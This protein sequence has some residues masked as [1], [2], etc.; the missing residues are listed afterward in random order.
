MKKFATLLAVVACATMAL[1]TTTFHSATSGTGSISG[2]ITDSATGYPIADAKV[3]VNCHTYA[4][5]GNDGRYT[6]T[7]LAAGDY[8]VTAMKSG[9]AMKAYPTTV[10]VDD[11]QAVT[12]IDIALAASGGGG[13]NGSISGTVYDQ[14]TNQPI[15]GAK[16]TAG[17]CRRKATTASDGTYTITGLSD[18]FYTVRAMKSGYN[19]AT[20]PNQ[21]EI[22]NGGAVTGIDFYLAQR[23]DYTAD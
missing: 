15:S 20:Y 17:G 22:V 23:G 1:A 5:S 3:M 19:C 10:H 13:G 12:G 7:G 8:R 16:V 9:Y 21:V 11:G 4:M 14:A 6:I 18:G 2:M